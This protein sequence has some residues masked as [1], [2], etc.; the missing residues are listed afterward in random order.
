MSDEL[1]G[2]EEKEIYCLGVLGD[3]APEVCLLIQ[4][5]SQEKELAKLSEI[6]FTGLQQAIQERYR[7]LRQVTA[8]GRPPGRS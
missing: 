7:E 6:L 1:I 4:T 2:R 3:V 8:A 5:A